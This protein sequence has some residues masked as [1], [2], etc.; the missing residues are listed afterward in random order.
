MIICRTILSGTKLDAR[1]APAG[2]APGMARIKDA[3]AQRK[4]QENKN[5]LNLCVFAP[6]R[7]T[8][9]FKPFSN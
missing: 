4:S 7:Q 8:V 2:G 6:L 3:K 1:S 5:T 9:L